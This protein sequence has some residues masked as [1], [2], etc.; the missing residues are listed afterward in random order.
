MRGGGDEIR[1][2]PS[3][4]VEVELGAEDRVGILE[5]VEGSLDG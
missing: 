1:E 3:G 2:G 4:G 5:V